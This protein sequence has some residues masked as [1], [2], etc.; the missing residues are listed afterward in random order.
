MTDPAQALR[1][2]LSNIEKRSGRSLAELSALL[3]ATGLVKHGE[4]RDHLKRELGMGH[5]DANT[6]VHHHLG[7]PVSEAGA[8]EGAVVADADDAA[9]VLAQIYAG[10]KA[11]L[12]P[13]HDALMDQIDRF[14]P[15]EVAPKKGYVSLRRKR[16][17]AMIGPATRTRVDL[18]LN[19]KGEAPTDRLVAMPPGG[20]CSHQV[21]LSDAAEVDAEVVAWVRRAYD[22]AG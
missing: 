12:R 19:M 1:T 11:G 18:G 21:R 5:G 3:R 17:F 6:L 14:G 7:Q 2:Q 15:F 10:P 16:Q 4:L 22:A 9:G 8:A 13:I 20:M